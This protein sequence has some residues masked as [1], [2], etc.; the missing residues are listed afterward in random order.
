MAQCGGKNSK[1]LGEAI[2]ILLEQ[3]GTD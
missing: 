1:K 3:V 2:G